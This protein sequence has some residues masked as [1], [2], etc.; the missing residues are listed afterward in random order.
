[1][2]SRVLVAMSGVEVHAFP[3]DSRANEV[4][5]R[6]AYESELIRSRRPRF[7]ILP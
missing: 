4:V 5:I 6:R 1:M 3:V 2:T 7:N